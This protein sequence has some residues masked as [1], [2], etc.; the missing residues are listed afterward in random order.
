MRAWAFVVGIVIVMGLVLPSFGMVFEKPTEG[1]N[2]VVGESF[3]VWIR[4][5]SG[6]VCESIDTGDMPAVPLN[7]MTGRFE[8]KMTL[9]RNHSLGKT[10]F[11]AS[12]EPSRKCRNAKTIINVVL[13]STTTLQSINAS[14]GGSKSTV[15]SVYSNPKG[16]RIKKE[17]L[18]NQLSAS[19]LYSDGVKRYLGEDPGNTYISS[20]EKVAIVEVGK[21][22][23]KQAFVTAVGVGKATITVQNGS[24]RDLVT[25]TVINKQCPADAIEP[26]GSLDIFKCD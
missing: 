5:K 25:V 9:N 24:Y 11:F 10:N 6:E 2:I 22:G 3:D 4:P 26:D 13:P 17:N 1:Q 8:G 21:H 20:D 15:M 14:V 16:E 12:G 7:P 18:T 19:G 23:G